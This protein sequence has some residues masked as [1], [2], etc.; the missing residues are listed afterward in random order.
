M[1]TGA[2]FSERSHAAGQPN[3]LSRAVETRRGRGQEL[4]DLTVS[5]PT[6]VGLKY[7][8][9]RLARALQSAPV[10]NYTPDPRG[11]LAARDSI[12]AL[13]R[14]RGRE[15][16]NEHV[17]IT[18][19]TSE[20]Y[21]YLFRLLCDAGGEVLVPQPSYPLL[22]VIARLENVKLVPYCLTY[23]GGWQMDVDSLKRARTD[24]SRAVVTINPN[25]PTGNF[26]A[27]HELRALVELELPIISDEVF[28]EYPFTTATQRNSGL[29]Q[30]DRLVF[31]LD[32]LSKLVG[33]PQLKLG[34][35]ALGGPER[36][37]AEAA[38]RLE[39]IADAFLSVNQPVQHALSSLLELGAEVNSQLSARCKENRAFL[40][41]RLE[42]TA[43]TL[44]HAEGGWSAMLRLPA[45]QSEE[46]WVVSLV[47]EVGVVTHPGWFY[48]LSEGSHCVVS[49]IIP[50]ARFRSGV[51][52]LVGYA[53]RCG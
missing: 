46:D 18:S 2:V 34:W 32:G 29:D 27:P 36:D 14:R 15:V 43:V 21:S 16:T 44:L 7:P 9:A 35:I 31:V 33:L 42:G 1:D 5:N 13:H 51:E 47:D 48:D 12:A 19:G 3:A 26:L 24:R 38:A 50:E 25:N 22:E 28:F 41:R 49:L 37:C 30:S 11:L 52:R 8:H 20:A 39:W 53:E 10:H 40:A 4:F 6:E 23:A 17:L 45:T